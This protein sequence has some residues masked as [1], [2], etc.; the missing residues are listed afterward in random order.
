MSRKDIASIRV[1]RPRRWR[2]R[3]AN[4][5]EPR[6]PRPTFTVEILES[7]LRPGRNDLELRASAPLRSGESRTLSFSYDPGPVAL[8]VHIE[9]TKA[10][11]L[12]VQDGY[13]EVTPTGRV[14]PVPGHE[15]WD[16]TLAVTGAFA[17]GRRVE[18]EL[19]LR[20]DPPSTGWGF[21]IFP[22]WGGRPDDP[23]VSPRRGWRF[24]LLW[25]YKRMSGFGC[26]FSEKIGPQPSRFAALY[27]DLRLELDVTYRLV[28]ET[29]PERSV[30]GAHLRWRQ[31]CKWWPA[32]QP[33]PPRWT[34]VSDDL[35]APL[36]DVPYAVAIFSL[37]AAV[38]FGNVSVQALPP[39]AT[40]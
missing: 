8:P 1:G 21:V 11:Q 10:T 39:G 12:D 16:R 3:R 27:R 22:L 7:E 17:G 19:T 29:W 26:S 34:E 38:E 25:Y 2:G 20:G 30:D 32:G 13:W 15:G 31:R 36:P 35:G 18:T 24:S 23:G 37:H 14:R 40:P 9:W 6:I 28:T 5:A 33:E 4:Q